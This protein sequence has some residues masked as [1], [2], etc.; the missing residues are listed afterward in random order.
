MHAHLAT[1][2]ERL[3]LSCELPWVS[4]LV[5]EATD[6]Q[7]QPGS[8]DAPTLRVVV[9]RSHRP[10]STD[11]WSP[12]S[13]DSWA[14][15]GHVVVRDVV[16]SGFDLRVGWHD[17]VPEFR[18]RW[19]PPLRTAAAG[20]VLRTRARLL[21]RAALLQYP[22]LWVASLRGRAPVHASALTAGE[23]GPALLVGPSGAGKTTL[24]EEEVRAGGSAAGDNIGVGDGRTVWG[25]VEPVRSERAGGRAAPHGRREGGLPHRV[26]SLDPVLLVVLRRGPTRRVEPCE[27]HQAARGLVA[28]TYAAGELRRYWPLHATLALGTGRGPAHPPVL[29]VAESFA[30][31]CR[32]LAVSLPQVRGVR[33]AELVAPQGA[34]TWR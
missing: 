27:P 1:G 25:V 31:R 32:C 20:R 12:I 3:A 14:A 28:S 2:G 6:G 26:E 4:G 11:G 29:T 8:P 18:F 13:R 5:A 9:E 10:F 17:E 22:V 23:D 30:A 19:R 33:V 15:E 7:L 34:T 24:V 21:Q 16:T